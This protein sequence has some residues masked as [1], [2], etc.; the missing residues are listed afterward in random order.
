MPEFA[1]SST[2]VDLSRLPAPKVVEQL[3]YETV[4]A[5]LVADLQARVPAFD[6]TLE[7]E[8][9][10]KLLEVVAYRELL[11]R[12]QFNDRARQL[13]TAYATGAN[14][15]HLAALVGVF[16]L[17]LEPAVP[18]QNKPA[19]YEADEALRQRIVLA[20][21]SWSVA[22]PE[23]AYVYHAKSADGRVADAS[24]TSPAPG[25]VLVTIL[26]TEGDGTP[27]AAVLD[28]VRAIV[29]G[30]PVRP[31]GDA[32]TVQGPT[33]KLFAV[34]AAISTFS[35]PDRDL[36]LT[37]ARASLDRFLL[38]S[39]RLGRDIPLS[40]LHAALTVAGVQKVA[41]AAPLAD[42]VCG[43]TEA[44]RCTAIALTHAGFGS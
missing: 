26:S 25:E 20:P 11:L 28:K 40:S 33:L 4:L 3:S 12:Q 44:A 29:N 43:A 5:A 39:R 15:D 32:V 18:A 16:R 30:R 8:P 21:E 1:V 42:T 23:L 34:T 6:A 22:G 41:L 35:G 31:L 24:A 7:S 19:V 13:M 10:M 9:A 37:A 2:A 36:V 38:D 17:L 27:S 14:L